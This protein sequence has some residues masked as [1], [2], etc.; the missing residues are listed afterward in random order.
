MKEKIRNIYL[1]GV[2]LIAVIA[3]L[4][5]TYKAISYV[6][7][8]LKLKK[9]YSKCHLIKEGMM[10][11]DMY[12]ILGNDIY[13]EYEIEMSPGYEYHHFLKYPPRLDYE[14]YLSIEIDPDKTKVV[15]FNPQNCEN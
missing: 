11:K 14:Y 6:D 5:S 4:Y 9:I 13:P 10:L 8:E 15:R 3:V 7:Y 1:N 12:R 2:T